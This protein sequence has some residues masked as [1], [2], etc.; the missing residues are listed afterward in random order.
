LAGANTTLSNLVAT[1]AINIDLEPNTGLDIDIGQSD[2]A[3][4]DGWFDGNMDIDGECDVGG[5][6][7][8]RGNVNLGS[9]ASDNIAFLGDTTG[10]ITPNVTNTDS[11]GEDAKRYS[12]LYNAV[13]LDTLEI[14]AGQQPT[15]GTNRMAIFCR[16][17]S[18]S[19]FKTEM[20]VRFQTGGTI[21]MFKEA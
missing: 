2:N 9:D 15:I 6:A 18:S 11:I 5:L 21:L 17:D 20:R 7:D 3:F 12:T 16:P 19:P 1:V 8:L 14:G 4:H 10:N 13:A